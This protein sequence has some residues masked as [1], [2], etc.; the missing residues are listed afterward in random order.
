MVG[1]NY[2]GE[3]EQS[4]LKMSK[5]CADSN[6]R[7]SRIDMAAAEGGGDL[8]CDYAPVESEIVT[9][10]SPITV[11][12]DIKEVL[13]LNE[14]G[15]EQIDMTVDKSKIVGNEFFTF[16][17]DEL[18]VLMMKTLGNMGYRFVC[19]FFVGIFFVRTDFE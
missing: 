17:Q 16:T 19:G 12:T 13:K 9:Q 18:I 4:I 1:R 7:S 14:G 6:V 10:V 2:S 11:N 8:Y 5:I 3:T 15:I